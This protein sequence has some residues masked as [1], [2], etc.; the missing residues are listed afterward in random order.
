MIT[1][2]AVKEQLRAL[3][4]LSDVDA[5]LEAAFAGLRPQAEGGE[6]VAIK[7]A[8]MDEGH[9]NPTR[10]QALDRALTA[11]FGDEGEADDDAKAALALEALARAIA[12]ARKDEDTVQLGGDTYALK[13]HA[14]KR[15][16]RGTLRLQNPD[17]APA[18]EAAEEGE[19]EDA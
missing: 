18:E 2:D 19:T 9:K 13:L 7:V 15:G 12:A 17:A 14:P 4:P 5:L 10:S 6:W 11:A 8:R 3:G 16:G 1:E